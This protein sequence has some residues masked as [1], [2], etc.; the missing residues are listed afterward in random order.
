[1][2]WCRGPDGGRSGFHCWAKLG[3][4]GSESLKR[5]WKYQPV[6][7]HDKLYIGIFLGLHNKEK[8][9]QIGIILID[10]VIITIIGNNHSCN[11]FFIF[12]EKNHDDATSVGVF[13][14]YVDHGEL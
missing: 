7:A 3:R 14:Q 2:L 5:N 11:T 8:Q 1:M 9:S 10:S 13:T 6:L 12:T 4:L